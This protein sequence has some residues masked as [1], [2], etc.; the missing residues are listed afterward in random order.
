MFKIGRASAAVF[1]VVGGGAGIWLGT[2][3]SCSQLIY[4]PLRVTYKVN[5]SSAVGQRLIWARFPL[6]LSFIKESF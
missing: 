6:S 2:T 4:I 1:M 5:L 3:C